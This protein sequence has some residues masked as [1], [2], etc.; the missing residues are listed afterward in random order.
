MLKTIFVIVVAWASTLAHARIDDSVFLYNVTNDRTEYQRNIDEVRSIASITKLMTAMVALDYDK[1]LS[2]KLL[3]SKRVKGHL[4]V[5]E[6][7]REQLLKALL[8]KHS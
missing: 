6:Y 4:P 3:L 1:D 5:Q 2:R 7:T 8:I